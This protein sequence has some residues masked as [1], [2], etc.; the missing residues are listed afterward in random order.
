MY[1]IRYVCIC[2]LSK[3]FLSS[4]L[5]CPSLLSP[6]LSSLLFFS[7]LL[8]SPLPSPALPSP[9]LPS[10]SF[11]PPLLVLVLDTSFG[12]GVILTSEKN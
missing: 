5:L 11:S 1:F 12:V 7:P 3:F 8:L 2:S 4:P 9:S 10:F 6:P